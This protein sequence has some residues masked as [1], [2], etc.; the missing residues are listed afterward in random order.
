MKASSA[1]ILSL[2]LGGSVLFCL[3]IFPLP[4]L[5]ATASIVAGIIA[6]RGRNG[7]VKVQV[8]QAIT[9][10]MIGVVGVGIS[11]A[12]V[13]LQARGNDTLYNALRPVEGHLEISW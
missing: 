6:L 9:G 8:W 12:A 5:P 4:I 11:L 3:G 10:M 2:L 1:S 13:I 7:P